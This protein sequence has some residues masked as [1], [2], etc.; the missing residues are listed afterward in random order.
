MES[1]TPEERQQA[2]W[3]VVDDIMW[4]RHFNPVSVGVN[5]VRRPVEGEDGEVYWVDTGVVNISIVGIMPVDPVAKHIADSVDVDADADEIGLLVVGIEDAMSDEQ[6]E[7]YAEYLEELF[8][9]H[10]S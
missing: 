3:A 2:M 5:R 9:E 1:V 6:A 7:I 4:D 10:D 8:D